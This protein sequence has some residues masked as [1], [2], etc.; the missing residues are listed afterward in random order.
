VTSGE[1]AQLGERAARL[2]ALA[3]QHDIGPGLT[4]AEFTRIERDY[5][6]EFADDHRAFLTVGLPLNRQAPNRTPAP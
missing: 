4:D 2:L 6:V 5:D 3:G 1:G